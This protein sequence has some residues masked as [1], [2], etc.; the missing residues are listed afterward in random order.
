MAERGGVHQAEGSWSPTAVSA[1]GDQGNHRG[2]PIGDFVAAP[3]LPVME[4]Q[5]FPASLVGSG[6]ADPKVD[7]HTVH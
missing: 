7:G 4:R 6:A 2:T 3:Q 5:L 1:R